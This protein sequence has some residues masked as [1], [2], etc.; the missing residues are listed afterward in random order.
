MDGMFLKSNVLIKRVSISCT[1][2]VVRHWPALII[3][4]VTQHRDAPRFPRRRRD[5][6]PQIST[7]YH[8]FTSA[9]VFLCR[10]LLWIKLQE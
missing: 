8:R 2:C 1:L 9:V 4:I 6:Q 3:L 10:K 5:G 7:G